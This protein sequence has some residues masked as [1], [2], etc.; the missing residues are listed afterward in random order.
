MAKAERTNKVLNL[1]Q[2]SKFVA[3]IGVLKR[4]YLIAGGVG[5][6][7]DDHDVWSAKVTVWG[8]NT[9]RHD[10]H[11]LFDGIHRTVATH[12]SAHGFV[13]GAAINYERWADGDDFEEPAFEEGLRVEAVARHL[14]QTVVISKRGN[15]ANATQR[16][17]QRNSVCIIN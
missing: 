17:K 7:P 6:C 14:R 13:F 4:E 12:C 9:A 3:S 16:T 10:G 1:K 2:P 15:N 8:G 5:G 11:C